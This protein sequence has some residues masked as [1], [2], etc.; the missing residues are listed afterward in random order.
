MQFQMLHFLNP[1][2]EKAVEIGGIRPFCYS[3]R[4][5]AGSQKSLTPRLGDI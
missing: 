5:N 3:G 2:V 1:M 4:T